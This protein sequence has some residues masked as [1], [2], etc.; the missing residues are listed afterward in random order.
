MTQ[1]Y[2]LHIGLNAVDPKHYAGWSGPLNACEA[3]AA[4]LRKI[5]LSRKFKTAVLL[6][7]KAKRGAVSGAIRKIGKAMKK[8]DLFV[9]SY[10]G[11]GGQLPDLNRDEPDR[12]D[13]TWCLYDGELVDDELYALLSES[14]SGARVLVLSDSCHSGTVTR[15]VHYDRHRNNARHYGGATDPGARIAYRSMPMGV[16]LN[17]YR[18]NESFYKKILANKK[19]A[20]AEDSVKAS[21]LLISGCQDNQESLDGDFNGLFTG[22]LLQVWKDGRFKGNHRDL[23]RE[24]VRM[25][26]PDQTPNL[27]WA[28]QPDN[29]FLR[30][31]PFTI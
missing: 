5:A 28:G 2:S 25:M 11:H 15:A 17:T 7:R 19:L 29:N 18:R 9:L 8:G 27:F 10:S 30:Q 24:I 1:G 4:D 12:F 26:P 21:V 20:K 23:H 22:T 13:E 3:D 31:K 14:P 6:T 16:A